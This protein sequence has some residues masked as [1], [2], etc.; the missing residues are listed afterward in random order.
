MLYLLAQTGRGNYFGEVD[1][2]HRPIFHGVEAHPQ[3]DLEFAV[4]DITDAYVFSEP[5]DNLVDYAAAYNHLDGLRLVCEHIRERGRNLAVVDAV[6][7]ALYV[8]ERG[9]V[10]I[11]NPHV[12]YAIQAIIDYVL[13]LLVERHEIISLVVNYQLIGRGGVLGGF[14]QLLVGSVL[15]LVKSYL[16]IF[17]DG[18][19][20]HFNI[21]EERRIFR[22]AALGNGKNIF[23]V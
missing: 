12:C 19:V 6:F 10:Q 18:I 15:V 20:D 5:V 11:G 8:P 14:V 23:Y 21:I 3:G 1:I 16:P 4:P 22:F 17:F 13:P 2:L 9:H 7:V